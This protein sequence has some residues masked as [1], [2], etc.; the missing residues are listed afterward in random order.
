MTRGVEAESM[1][2][3]ASSY[4]RL[5]E[6]HILAEGRAEYHRCRLLNVGTIQARV[7]VSSGLYAADLPQ[8]IQMLFPVLVE[9]AR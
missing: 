6:A 3:F 9:S 7:E 2:T 8:R 4:R 5:P 1:E